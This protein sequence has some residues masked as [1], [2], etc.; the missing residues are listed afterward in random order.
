[1]DDALQ[2]GVAV[3]AREAHEHLRRLVLCTL[4][5]GL[6][7]IFNRHQI[8][9]SVISR[10]RR[11]RETGQAELGIPHPR[12]LGVVEHRDLRS[13]VDR[14]LLQDG[15]LHGPIFR[16]G[17]ALGKSLG[18]SRVGR[19]PGVRRRCDHHL[20]L[21]RNRLELTAHIDGHPGHELLDH[22]RLFH[23]REHLDVFG[24][25]RAPI[26]GQQVKGRS[27][28]ALGAPGL[29][30]LVQEP[31]APLIEELLHLEGQCRLNARASHGVR[32]SCHRY[33]VAATADCKAEPGSHVAYGPAAVGPARTSS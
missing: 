6:K 11:L 9:P 14:R 10:L 22:V 1:M 30:G 2:H 8:R 15:H 5:E 31:T 29:E 3:V 12:V 18:A 4:V 17:A 13:R 26:D 33:R 19:F 23:N 20:Q 32:G 7:L 28:D 21:H 27:F 25:Q 16:I 24:C